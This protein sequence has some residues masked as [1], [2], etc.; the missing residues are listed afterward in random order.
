L[1]CGLLF[2]MAFLMKQPGIVFAAFAA[3]WLAV[4]G[5]RETAPGR[6]QW[7]AAASKLVLFALGVAVPFLLTCFV[8]WRAGVFGKFWFWTFS[9]ARQYASNLSLSDGLLYLRSGITRAT[10]ATL[11]LWLLGAAGL[12]AFFWDRSVR[13]HAL[14]TAGLL[15]FSFVA[16]S[17]GFYFRQHYFILML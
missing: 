14:F 11:S 4:E 10:M 9:Y 13:K 16:V 2:G 12:S 6:S 8:L 15:G 17:P 3:I 5:R 7:L 1:F